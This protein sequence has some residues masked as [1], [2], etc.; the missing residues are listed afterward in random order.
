[1]PKTLTKLG[2]AALA[3]TLAM[4]LHAQEQAQEQTEAMSAD[5]VVA[6]VNGTDITLGEMLVVRA[7]L[8][9]Q[10]Q[11]LGDDV[12]WDGILDQLV[13][14]EVL[15][16]D[17]KAVETKRVDLSLKTERRTLLAA[18]TVSAVADAAVTDEALQAA[19]DAQFADAEQG[20]EYNASHILVETEDEAK[21]IIEELNGGSDFAEV[22]KSK[23]TGPSG[24]NGGELGWFSKGMMV[25]PFE[26]AVE[27]M[28]P[29]TISEA[30]VQTQFGWHVIKLN[31]TRAKEAP[32]LDEVRDQL[33][34]QVQQEA[35]AAYMDEAEAGAE[36]TRKASGDVDPSI[37][38]NLELLED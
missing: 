35:V 38:S 6:T 11:Q 34:Q 21:A 1:M 37:L 25:E 32:K 14:Q 20:Q 9:E 7:S 28:E 12:L 5:T 36:I 26:T 19:Y 17:E 31:E 13:Q 4:P 8:P 24:P 27:G 15:A 22:A 18:E 23:S 29:G 16:Q 2:A 10:Y 33:A 3:L 30:P